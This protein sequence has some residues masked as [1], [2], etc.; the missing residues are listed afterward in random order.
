MEV[1]NDGYSRANFPGARLW[2]KVTPIAETAAEL[3]YNRLV[4][5]D[6]SARQLFEGVDMK[7]QGR[8]LM[9]MIGI[10]VAGLDDIA[11]LVPALHGLG[12]QHVGFGVKGPHFDSVGAAL[13]WTLGQGLGDAFTKEVE[14]AW[15]EVYGVLAG[16]MK[17]GL[18]SA[19]D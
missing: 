19:A 7:E 3:F 11:S 1:K 15:T 4:E 18:G 17:E 9:E 5:T 13:L 16:T 12:E 14:E 6:D 10:A 2:Q 8:K